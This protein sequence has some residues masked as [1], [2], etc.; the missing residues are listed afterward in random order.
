MGWILKIFA[1]LVGVFMMCMVTRTAKQKKMNEVQS[2]FWFIGAIGIIFMGLFHGVLA[3][4]ANILGVWW[5][6]AILIFFL[7][8]L[9]LFIGFNHAKEIS[10]LKAEVTELSMQVSLLKYEK[11]QR[12]AKES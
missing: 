7:I 12:E 2:I 3:W 8:V 5:A 9:L 4:M 10:I 11:E 6:P 1:V